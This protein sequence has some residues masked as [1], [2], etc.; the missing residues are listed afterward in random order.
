[1]ITRDDCKQLVS[2]LAFLAFF[3]VSMFLILQS[4]TNRTPP[5]EAF[6]L[7]F[8]IC[9]AW[10]LGSGAVLFVRMR[11]QEL[12]R[13]FV[14]AEAAFRSRWG[15]NV[16][17]ARRAGMGRWVPIFAAA[18]LGAFL[19]LAALSAGAFFYSAHK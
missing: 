13:R 2:F 19:L 18:S 1:M 6:A 15:L 4:M 3:G 9:L 5:T 8:W 7:Y 10:A 12:W 16:E 17:R 14:D 11:H